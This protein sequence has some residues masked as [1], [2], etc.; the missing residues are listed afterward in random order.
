MW[1]ENKTN[2]TKNWGQTLVL[3]EENQFLLQQWHCVTLVENLVTI[4]EREQND[5]HLWWYVTV[6]KVIMATMKLSKEMKQ[7]PSKQQYYSHTYFL[8]IRPAIM[9]WLGWRKPKYP[10]KNLKLVIC[11]RQTWS[12][13]VISITLLH[14]WE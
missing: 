13:Q 10:E 4:H 9:F 5:K 3:Q 11:H 1:R 7:V 14:L 8:W 12:H 2:P 6:N